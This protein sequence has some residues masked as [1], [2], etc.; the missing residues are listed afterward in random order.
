VLKSSTVAVSVREKLL[1]IH[2][3]SLTFPLLHIFT[4]HPMQYKS[5]ARFHVCD[6][7]N[8]YKG[9]KT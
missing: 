9:T 6:N 4:P 5:F 2:V 1:V 7:A 3:R 8:V